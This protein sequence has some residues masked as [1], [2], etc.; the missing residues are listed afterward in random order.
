MVRGCAGAEVRGC[1]G[2]GGAGATEI[3][4]GAKSERW[5]WVVSQVALKRGD[6]A[7]GTLA[8]EDHFVA[9]GGGK[10]TPIDSVA[11]MILRFHQ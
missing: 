1:G 8:E 11:E 7:A 10:V 4:E 9:F 6:C 2:A 5:V 3:R